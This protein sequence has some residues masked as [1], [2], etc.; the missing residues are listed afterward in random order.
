MNT[1]FRDVIFINDLT[2]FRSWLIA[3]GIAIIGSNFIE[4]LGFLE[5][6]AHDGALLVFLKI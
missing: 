4:D 2:M 3:L 5:M 6:K 1:A